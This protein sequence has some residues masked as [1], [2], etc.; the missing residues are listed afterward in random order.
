MGRM[1]HEVNKA[2]ILVEGAAIRRMVKFEMSL[3][4]HK[5]QAGAGLQRA[6]GSLDK[7]RER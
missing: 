4:S 1:K 5:C 7:G 2:H 6:K 3:I